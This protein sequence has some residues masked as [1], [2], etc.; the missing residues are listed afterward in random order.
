MDGATA[1]LLL[2]FVSPAET[3]ALSTLPFLCFLFVPVLNQLE[4]LLSDMKADVT[5]LPNMLSRVPPVAARLQM[6]E[7]SI[8]SQLANRG[9]E[10]QQQ[11][12]ER[13]FCG[14]IVAQT[15]FLLIRKVFPP[16]VLPEP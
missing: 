12:R 16:V 8:L 4:E 11:V 1:L 6:S 3:L 5:R 13:M 14:I 2:A 9:T 10:P 7:R 15:L